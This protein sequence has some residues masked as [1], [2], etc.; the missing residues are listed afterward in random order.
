MSDDLGKDT[1]SIYI[2]ATDGRGDKYDLPSWMVQQ[3]MERL[4]QSRF[5]RNLRS[6]PNEKPERH[7]ESMIP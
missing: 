7:G 5:A 2:S 4:V 6:N 3:E 1:R